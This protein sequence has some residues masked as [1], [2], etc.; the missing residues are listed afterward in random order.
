LK[1]NETTDTSRNTILVLILAWMK[2]NVLVDKEFKRLLTSIWLKKVAKQVLIEEKAKPNV[3]VGLVITGQENI[4]E[5]NQ[6]YL[7]EDRPTD[8]LSFPMIETAVGEDCFINPPGSTVRIGE[9]IISYPQAKKQA[10]EH[11]HRVKKEVAILIIHGVLHLLGYD[12]DTS[13]NKRVMRKKEKD[14][15]QVI[16]EKS[17]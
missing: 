12:H 8:V 7:D 3:E 16:E 13:A 9:V 10:I 6:R 2:V 17:L 14:I 11:G 4:Q 1:E 15:L 5:L